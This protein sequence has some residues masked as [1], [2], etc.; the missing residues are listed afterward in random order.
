VELSL[1]AQA[2]KLKK[3]NEELR[4]KLKE[5]EMKND[6]MTLK[7]EQSFSSMQ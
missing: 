6:A 2:K 4:S 7:I 3:Q 1:D 5:I